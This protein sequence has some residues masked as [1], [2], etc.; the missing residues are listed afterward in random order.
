MV[1]KLSYSNFKVLKKIIIFLLFILFTLTGYFY[2]QK[3]F[4]QTR[5]AII[6]SQENLVTEPGE[7]LNIYQNKK[8]HYLINYPKGWFLGYFGDSY[9]TAYD[10]WFVSHVKDIKLKNGGVPNGVK[11]K[12]VSFDLKE[13]KKTDPQF[14]SINKPKDWLNWIRTN[15]LGNGQFLDSNILINGVKAVKTEYIKPVLAS[16]GPGITIT[17]LHPNKDIIL[18]IQYSGKQPDYQDNI[19]TFEQIINSLLFD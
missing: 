19:F 4:Y 8:Y 18:Q 9:R 16:L 2:F 5:P 10:V 7:K 15:Q 11:V 1:R 3:N 17:L 6:T 13:L 14:E 12:I